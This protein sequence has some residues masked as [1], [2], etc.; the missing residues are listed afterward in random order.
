MRPPNTIFYIYNI[1]DSIADERLQDE[2]IVGKISL[3]SLSSTLVM[4]FADATARTTYF[5]A[6]PNSLFLGRQTW[7]VDT[8]A[9]ETWNGTTWI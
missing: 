6:N 3:P 9:L 5:T 4:S 1:D 2:Q 7:N 8:T